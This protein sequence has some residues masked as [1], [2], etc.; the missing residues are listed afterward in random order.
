MGGLI[1]GEFLLVIEKDVQ[2]EF[3]AYS[4]ARLRRVM[5]FHSMR[6]TTDDRTMDQ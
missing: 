1:E 5:E 6:T 3:Q 4:L 2:G